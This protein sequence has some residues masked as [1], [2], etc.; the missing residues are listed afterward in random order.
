MWNGERFVRSYRLGSGKLNAYLDDYAFMIQGLTELYESTFNS[1]W[2]DAA[3]D[4]AHQ[5]SKLFEDNESG[6]F[7]YMSFVPVFESAIP[8]TFI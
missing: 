1:R 2:L 3:V 8:Y 7:F 6:G 5:M 4:I